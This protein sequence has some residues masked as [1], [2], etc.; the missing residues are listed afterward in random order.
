[1]KNR[2]IVSCQPVENSPLDRPEIVAAFAQAV[3]ASGAVAVRIEGIDNISAVR[4]ATD[5]PI[6]GLIKRDLSDSPVRITPWV[7]DVISIIEAGADIVAFDATQRIR[8]CTV[9]TLVREIHARKRLAM[10]D[11]AVA[12]DG[13]LARDLGCEILG[14]TLSGYTTETVPQLPDLELV[15]RLSKMGVFTIA[16]GRYHSPDQAALALRAGADAIVVGSA[17]TRPEHVTHWFA[18]AVK[19][20][21]ADR[22]QAS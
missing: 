4:A 14:S 8:P 20:A 12:E 16:E 15:T 21:T 3:V 6:I 13:A 19:A 5:V 18:D 22:R 2:L 11:C 17:I 7:S 1:M 9:E 10:A